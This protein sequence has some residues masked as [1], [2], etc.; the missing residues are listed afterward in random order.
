MDWFETN[1]RALISQHPN[2][3]QNELWIVKRNEDQYFVK[4]KD[5]NQEWL[6]YLINNAFDLVSFKMSWLDIA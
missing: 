5:D 6:R 3:F 4:Y 1:A 2:G